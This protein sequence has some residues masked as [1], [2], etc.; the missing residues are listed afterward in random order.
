[1]KSGPKPKGRKEKPSTKPS[2]NVTVYLTDLEDELEFYANNVEN[3]FND[4]TDL[5][6]QMKETKKE[7][8]KIL[9]KWSKD[10]TKK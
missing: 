5:H 3:F 8:G 1:M 6:E 2:L 7:L 9:D 10:E 4:L